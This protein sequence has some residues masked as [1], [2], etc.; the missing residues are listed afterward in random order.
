MQMDCVLVE[1][2][3][4]VTLLFKVLIVHNYLL[5]DLL[6]KKIHFYLNKIIIA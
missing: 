5:L 6:V 4:Y 2:D 3:V 1:A